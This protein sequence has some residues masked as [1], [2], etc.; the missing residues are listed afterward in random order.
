MNFITAQLDSLTK[1]DVV[2]IKVPRM[3]HELDAQGNR[4]LVPDI[5]F[6]NDP[7]ASTWWVEGYGK[8]NAPATAAHVI[9]HNRPCIHLLGTP[10][11]ATLFGVTWTRK[12]SWAPSIQGSSHP[13][14]VWRRGCYVTVAFDV[15][16]QDIKGCR[17]KP[18]S[19]TDAKRWVYEL[20]PAKLEDEDDVADD[21]LVGLWRD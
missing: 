13:V 8:V 20:H 2:E 11:R 18:T 5:G 1:S 14:I 3:H 15:V 9:G 17:R 7:L 19:L 6:E 16:G 10:P 12:L 4:I 21:I